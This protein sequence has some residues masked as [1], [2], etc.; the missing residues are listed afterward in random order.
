MRL[1][2][3][4]R[5]WLTRLQNYCRKACM[6]KSPEVDNTCFVNRCPDKHHADATAIL[7]I[8]ELKS[9]PE[10][11]AHTIEKHL[12]AMFG[13]SR[14]TSQ[15][16]GMFIRL[17]PALHKVEYVDEVIAGSDGQQQKV[18]RPYTL[19][20]RLRVASIP[21]SEGG[22]HKHC[23]FHRE[24]LI[25]HLIAAAFFNATS[26]LKSQKCVPYFTFVTGLFHDCV[27]GE[28]NKK[29]DDN[30]CP[31]HGEAMGL[32]KANA[33]ANTQA[34]A[35]ANAQATASANTQ[36]PLSTNMKRTQTR[37]SDCA[38]KAAQCH[39][40]Y[41]VDSKHVPELGSSPKEH[42]NSSIETQAHCNCARYPAH[43]L[44]GSIYLSIFFRH[45]IATIPGNFSIK[46]KIEWFNAM[47]RT[48][49]LHMS[50]HRCDDPEV[51]RVVLSPETDKVKQLCLHM[52]VG[53]NLGKIAH[54][55]F[56]PKEPFQKRFEHLWYN[57]NILPKEAVPLQ[58]LNP[59]Q[60]IVVTVCAPSGSGKSTWIKRFMNMFST[61]HHM[62]HISRD[63][64]IGEIMTGVNKRL[65]GEKYSN[66]YKAYDAC[67]KYNNGAITF[68]E[69]QEILAQAQG[70]TS[71][72]ASLTPSTVPHVQREVDALFNK[73]I[74]NSLD[75]PLVG[76]VIIDTL[77]NMWQTAAEE[78]P[79]L[80]EHIQIDVPIVNLSS[81]VSTNNGLTEQEQLRLS[82]KCTLTSPANGDLISKWFN[83]IAQKDDNTKYQAPPAILTTDADGVLC[84]VGWN[85]SLQWMRS[86]IGTSPIL[87]KNLDVNLMHKNGCKF[88]QHIVHKY[89]GDMLKIRNVYFKVWDVN[90]S[91]IIPMGMDMRFS[92]EKK[93]EYIEK[94]V[95]F[96]TFLHKE[97]V[98]SSLI[99]K[100]QLEENDTLFWNTLFSIVVLKYKDGYAGEKFWCNRFM[101]K[102]RGLILFIDPFTGE[103]KDL[104]FL[105]DRGAETHSKETKDKANGQDD[106]D[107]NHGDNLNIIKTAL[108]NDK[109]L[110][111]YLIQKA[112]GSLGNFTIYS[113]GLL[114]IMHAY[115][116]TFGT[117]IAKEIA[118]QSLERSGGKFLAVLS[119]QGTKSITKDMI[120]F[121]T[122]AIFGGIQDEQGKPLVSR[123]EMHETTPIDIWQR[124]GNKVLDK[125]FALFK[126]AYD[127][128]KDESITLM[129]EMLCAKRR[130]AFSGKEHE[131]FA[132]QATEDDFLFLGFGY[133]KNEVSIPHCVFD[134]KGIFKQPAYWIIKS[135]EQVNKMIRDLQLVV[136]NKM[137]CAD[138]LK[139][140]PPQNPKEFKTLHPE[141]FVLYAYVDKN[142]KSVVH[143]AY[144][145]PGELT[146]A[147][148]KTLMYYLA[149]KFKLKSI[150]ELVEFGRQSPGHFPLCDVLYNIYASDKLQHLLRPIHREFKRFVDVENPTSESELRSEIHKI[151][152]PIPE[153]QQEKTGAGNV[154]S[155]EQRGPVSEGQSQSSAGVHQ[156]KEKKKVMH[157]LELYT[158]LQNK[159]EETRKA[160]PDQK[161]PDEDYKRAFVHALLSHKK[162]DV[163][164]VKA[165]CL[166]QAI[167]SLFVDLM[168]VR[169]N[170]EFGT[171]IQTLTEVNELISKSEHAPFSAKG[172]EMFEERARLAIKDRSILLQCIIQAMPWNEQEWKKVSECKDIALLLEVSFITQM[173]AL[174]NTPS[175]T[176]PKN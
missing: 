120:P 87:R 116:L 35:S 122:T 160:F 176:V 113:G 32:G 170:A 50:L 31:L 62:V 103:V 150:K 172:R 55:S 147:K 73:T 70:L 129:F 45:I 137:D 97:G 85:D 165:H 24:S 3:E 104:R 46:E 107:T 134:I 38:G 115:V 19:L 91:G 146:Y 152:G 9:L 108:L 168:I 118:K 44:L 4:R 145:L 65:K 99:T 18:R 101:L 66:M 76:V 174:Q 124:H 106:A 17:H 59:G 94:L 154:H 74:S 155:D 141:G 41:M 36:A 153:V 144:R 159:D 69:L 126:L 20:D 111:G 166:R 56:E 54:A 131:E 75:D 79:S 156:R 117:D 15:I 26:A 53:D 138:F 121:A 61:K 167:T 105:F 114:A 164:D 28:C 64:C 127:T 81:N 12:A 133:A 93:K 161:K 48:V 7:A 25:V 16:A 67:N 34:N 100:E 95:E 140:Y 33:S 14:F 92:P 72:F 123:E 51:C 86:A 29:H 148:V 143:E 112:D 22:C 162:G 169:W 128:H 43:G 11:A 149:H 23:P 71:R 102:Y 27:K 158:H 80:M 47:K 96:T 98:L 49:Q 21:N 1:R 130:D 60:K 84:E 52:F 136:E 132:C 58:F 88:M 30:P 173:V 5:A 142:N 119:T 109:P 6:T 39:D 90:M 13:E 83:P 68:E 163:C 89:K 57:V 37:C 171:Q 157:P 151:Y 135:A 63:S 125:V 110:N 2:A 40:C 8:L 175:V 82:G 10:D 139:A 42:D 78:M 77:K